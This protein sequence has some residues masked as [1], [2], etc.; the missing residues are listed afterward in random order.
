MK[1]AFVIINPVAGKG[2]IK[3]K[4]FAL[5]EALSRK[6]Y[7]ATVYLTK[8]CGDG[9]TASAA[10]QQADLIV[11]SG[12]DGTLREVVS[13]CMLNETLKA[14]ILYLPAGTTNDFAHTLNLAKNFP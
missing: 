9:L 14:P 3:Q 4:L 11:A 7:L 8:S 12:G 2:I 6:D 5:V 13:G 1:R 10:L